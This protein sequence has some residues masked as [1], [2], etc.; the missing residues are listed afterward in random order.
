MFSEWCKEVVSVSYYSRGSRGV[1]VGRE[2]DS[3]HHCTWWAGP[4]VHVWNRIQLYDGQA[5]CRHQWHQWRRIE[6]GN[7]TGMTASSVNYVSCFIIGVMQSLRYGFSREIW[8]PPS[9]PLLMLRNTWMVPCPA[10][11]RAVN[12]EL[13]CNAFPF[14]NS[15]DFLFLDRL[16]HGVK[17]G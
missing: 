6:D 10:W 2:N 9:H 1:R 17:H 14:E 4:A 8:H 3:V 5:Q 15:Y 7:Y 13:F 11:T 12:N 16:R